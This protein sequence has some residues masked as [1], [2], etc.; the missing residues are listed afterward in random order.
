MNSLSGIP[1]GR[2]NRPEEVAKLVA[3]LASDRAF[4]ITGSEYVMM[5]ER[6][7]WS[8]SSEALRNGALNAEMLDAYHL[9]IDARGALEI[10]PRETPFLTHESARRK[11][12]PWSF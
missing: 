4:S 12:S 9:L 3:F 8:E 1:L 10:D 11:T 5:A 6:S 7:R 2:P